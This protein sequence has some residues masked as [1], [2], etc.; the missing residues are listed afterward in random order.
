MAEAIRGD[1]YRHGDTRVDVKFPAKGWFARIRVWNGARWPKLERTWYGRTRRWVP[2][3][4]L[5]RQAVRAIEYAN[6]RSSVRLPRE[7]I[8]RQARAA[9]DNVRRET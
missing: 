9:L 2:W 4:S 1:I 6:R 3:F 7:E 8:K 5:E